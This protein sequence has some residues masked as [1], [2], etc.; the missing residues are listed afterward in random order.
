MFS[1]S[2]GRTAE[3]RLQIVDA[4]GT[5]VLT[6][7]DGRRVAGEYTLQTDIS[8]LPT[9]SYFVVLTVDGESKSSPL[10]VVR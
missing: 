7:F 2:I 3:T 8:H 6:F 9:G 5:P 1:Y 10:N 4:T